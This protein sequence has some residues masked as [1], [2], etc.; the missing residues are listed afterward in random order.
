MSD[1]KGYRCKWCKIYHVFPFYLYA[2]WDIELNHTCPSCGAVS[3]LYAGR[4]IESVPP[5]K[6]KRK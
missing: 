1:K 5:K 2:H 3:T 4:V 6:T